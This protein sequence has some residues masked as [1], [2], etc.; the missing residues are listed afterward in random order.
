MKRSYPLLKN[1]SLSSP[2]ENI[3]QIQTMKSVI[4]PIITVIIIA[5]GTVR[6][7]FV[8]SIEVQR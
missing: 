2:T 8:I 6:L 3:K 4:P 5:L 7:G 1:A